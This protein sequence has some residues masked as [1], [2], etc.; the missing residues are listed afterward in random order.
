[1]EENLKLKTFGSKQ[2]KQDMCMTKERNGQ[3]GASRGEWQSVMYQKE[4]DFLVTSL[5]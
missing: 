2:G 3:G 5:T 1:M 4:K